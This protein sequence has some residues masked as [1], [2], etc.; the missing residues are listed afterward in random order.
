MASGPMPPRGSKPTRV[1]SD[2]AAALSPTRRTSLAALSGA[3]PVSALRRGLCRA[4]LM[5]WDRG[6]AAGG[7]RHLFVTLERQRDTREA[8][9]VSAL[10]EERERMREPELACLRGDSLVRL[11]EDLLCSHVGPPT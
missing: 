7:G 6:V 5:A 8:V 10:T 11:A 3:R 2:S 9:P 4:G 1:P